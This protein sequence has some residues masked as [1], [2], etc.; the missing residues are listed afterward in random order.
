[1][2]PH[3]G[4]VWRSNATGNRF[5]VID[6]IPSIGLYVVA[7]LDGGSWGGPYYWPVESFGVMTRVNGV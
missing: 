2:Q 7:A 5:K 3:V 4:D 1:M 6:R